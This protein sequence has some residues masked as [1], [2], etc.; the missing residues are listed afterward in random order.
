MIERRIEVY[1]HGHIQPQPLRIGESGF[2]DQPE[3]APDIASSGNMAL[4]EPTGTNVLKAD[5]SSFFEKRWT[6]HGKSFV[7]QPER[8]RGIRHFWGRLF[9]YGQQRGT[10]EHVPA[11]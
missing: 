9:R 4:E 7:R 8:Q 1:R 3:K 10:I 2:P 11:G 5:E 6:D